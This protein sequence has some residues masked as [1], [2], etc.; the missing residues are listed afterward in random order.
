MLGWMALTAVAMAN[1]VP[2][3]SG[4]LALQYGRN[5]G[6]HLNLAGIVGEVKIN[7][8]PILAVG[9]R[10]GGQLGLGVSAS[11]SSAEAKFFSNLPLALKAEGY[12]GTGKTRPYAGLA[13]GVSRATGAGAFGSA[14]TASAY[15]VVGPMGTVMPELGIDLGMF[16]VALQ[17]SLL[18]GSASRIA[19][20]ATAGGAS[21]SIDPKDAP[22]LSG[23]TLQ[24]G[25]HFGGPRD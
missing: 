7:V 6:Q 19:E 17:H 12:L 18:F 25:I 22:S 20:S 21:V 15:S 8:L 23:T 2:T 9:V 13:V 11:E 3:V 14:T 10:T 5:W 4:D 24:L 1:D 16:R